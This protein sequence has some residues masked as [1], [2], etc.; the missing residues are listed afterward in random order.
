MVKGEKL[1]SMTRHILG[2]FRGVKGA[3]QFRRH[4][5]ENAQGNKASISV[6]YDALKKVGEIS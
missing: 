6:L 3:K 1:H 2:L 5:S 4:I